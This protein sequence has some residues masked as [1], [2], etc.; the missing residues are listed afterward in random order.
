MARI[1]PSAPIHVY[2]WTVREWNGLCAIR[3]CSR[4]TSSFVVSL[5]NAISDAISKSGDECV[6]SI[7]R[8]EITRENSRFFKHD[9]LNV[10]LPV[11]FICHVRAP[12]SN[13]GGTNDKQDDLIQHRV[14]Y[15]PMS[16]SSDRH[17]QYAYSTGRKMSVCESFSMTELVIKSRST[18][19]I[20]IFFLL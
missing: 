15:G 18:G 20:C 2:R 9:L 14:V 12:S 7:S 16:A 13:D 19:S 4:G 11:C 5:K 10:N 8:F 1:G 6:K 17:L 3:S